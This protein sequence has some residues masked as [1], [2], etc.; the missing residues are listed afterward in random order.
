M[1]SSENTA[2]TNFHT[3]IATT[4]RRLSQSWE[5]GDSADTS[6]ES[7]DTSNLKAKDRQNAI[8]FHKYMLEAGHRFLSCYDQ[9]LWYKPKEGIYTAFGKKDL[10]GYVGNCPNIHE[11]YQ[12]STGKQNAMMTQFFSIVDTDDEFYEKS[13]INTK[14]FM[15]FQNG[16]FDYKKQELKAF[17]PDY[18][19]TFKAPID[20]KDRSQLDSKTIKKVRQKLFTDIFGEEK[21]DFALKSLARALAGNV[22]DKRFFVVLGKTNS[23][24]GTLSAMLEN[25]FGLNK[26]IGGYDTKSLTSTGNKTQSWLYQ[27]KN[28]RIILGNEIDKDKPISAKQLTMCASGGDAI[29]SEVKWIEVQ[30]FRTQG[31]FFLFANKMPPIKSANDGSNSIE[32]RMVYI[33]TEYSYLNEDEYQKHKGEDGV[34][35]AD[36]A[37]KDDFILDKK[38]QEAFVY[39]LCSE[40]KSGPPPRIPECIL[41]K[42]R[43]FTPDVPL[44]TLIADLVQFT[45]KDSDFVVASELNTRLHGTPGANKSSVG[46]IMKKLGAIPKE[47]STKAL[48]GT[49]TCYLRFVW[50]ENTTIYEPMDDDTSS[51]VS[52]NPQYDKVLEQKE[53]LLK[54]KD[55]ELAKKDDALDKALQKQT[56]DYEKALKKKDDDLLKMGAEME[57]MKIELKKGLEV[58]AKKSKENHSDAVPRDDVEKQLRAAFQK[59]KEEDEKKKEEEEK[60]KK[61]LKEK[62]EAL[63]KAEDKEIEHLKQIHNMAQANTEYINDVEEGRQT[64]NEQK[65]LLK[66]VEKRFPEVKIYDDDDNFLPEIRAKLKFGYDKFDNNG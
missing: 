33:N 20:Y 32:N 39:L 37:L 48:G 50:K 24:K 34:R 55:E 54:K 22:S 38:Y 51:A 21:G 59:K 18:Y 16:V 15:A 36:A 29:T 58:L 1:A 4:A 40:Y 2:N 35:R 23:G 64:I 7:V 57:K 9:L 41:E 25:C 11:D 43:E 14:Y 12:E 6:T 61:L 8:Q 62:E 10:R 65:R 28:C 13:L 31:T 47:K 49:K 46:A 19:F 42:G 66:Q 26:F 44:D 27:N 5:T 63:N 56:F 52:S 30:T 17:S 60:L 3:P 53:R 45:G